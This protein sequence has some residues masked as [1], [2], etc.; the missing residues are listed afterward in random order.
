MQLVKLLSI[1]SLL[2]LTTASYADEPN[3]L[4]HFFTDKSA[5][6]ILYNVNQNKIINEY[7]PK[8]CAVRMPPDS[9]FKIA[10]SLMAFDQKLINQSTVFK[11]DGKDKGFSAW[12]QDKTPKTWL[13]D[14]TVWVSQQLTP[15]I[16]M[17][18]IE[19]YLKKFHY[20]NE[21]MSGNPG[22]N[23]G[24]TNAWLSSSLK[25]SGDEQL[26]FLKGLLNNTLP[27]SKEAMTNT[28]ENMFL[29]TTMNGW[30]LYGKTGSGIVIDK[31]GER[32]KDLQQGW[33]VGFLANNNQKYIFVMNFADLRKPISDYPQYA[34]PRAKALTLKILKDENLY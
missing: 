10:L 6:F 14:S 33:F 9:T 15:Q 24:L 31:N 2:F 18:K 34:G 29:K 21:D 28:K 32:S 12:N 7:N 11:W 17:S 26:T 23:D 4:A 30:K 8:Q 13:S 5:C 1:V 19:D 3:K 27:V 22:K 20:G 25:I 16:G